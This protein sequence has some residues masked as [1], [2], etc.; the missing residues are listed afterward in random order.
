[1]KSFL[2]N[3]K[4]IDWILVGAALL[5]TS[6]GLLFLYY[7]GN[8]QESLA[9]FKK[10]IFFLMIGLVLMFLTSLIDWGFLKDNSYIILISYLICLVLL[11]GLFV[12]AGK[13][14][15]VKSWFSF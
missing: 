11:G 1:M 12:F 15:G 4:K 10:Q 9:N 2:F 14:R 5:L 7:Y 8:N 6:F 13:I 3:F